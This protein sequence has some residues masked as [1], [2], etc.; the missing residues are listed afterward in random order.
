MTRSFPMTLVLSSILLLIGSLAVL[1]VEEPQAVVI[2]RDR[3]FSPKETTV[4]VGGMIRFDNQDEFQHQI[5]VASPTFSFDSDEQRPGESIEVQ[6]PVAGD[7]KV[8]CGIH[9]K[10]TLDVHVH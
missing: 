5:F 6:F 3:M 9:P 2:Q 10:M 7:F 1:A 4:P 8:L